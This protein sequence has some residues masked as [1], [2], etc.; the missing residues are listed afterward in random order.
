MHFDL[1]ITLGNLLDAAIIL[2]G[3]LYHFYKMASDVGQQRSVVNE[4]GC[5]LKELNAQSSASAL[6]I[7]RLTTLSESTE[8]RLASI[9]QRI[10][11]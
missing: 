4:H 5:N 2:G 10:N 6:S 1:S 11:K 8:R 3:L 9:E 7:S